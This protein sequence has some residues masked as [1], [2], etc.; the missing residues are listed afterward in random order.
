[1][2][3]LGVEEFRSSGFKAPGYPCSLGVQGLRV[4]EFR[5]LGV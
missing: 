4:F 1:M 2:W 3:G 5:G